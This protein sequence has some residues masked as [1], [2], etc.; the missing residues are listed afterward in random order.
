MISFTAS[1]KIVK[2]FSYSPKTIMVSLLLQNVSYG[3]V[4][5]KVKL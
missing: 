3:L 5:S 4:V 2:K 1:I